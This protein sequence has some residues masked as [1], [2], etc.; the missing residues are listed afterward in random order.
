MNLET[1]NEL[2][3]AVEAKNFS[4]V[5]DIL[6][7]KNPADIAN[8]I[9]RFKE[10]DIC[11]I[12]SALTVEQSGEIILELPEDIRTNVLTKLDNKAILNFIEELDSD[13]AADLISFSRALANA[14]ILV[15]LIESA[16]SFK[17]PLISNFLDSCRL[18]PRGFFAYL[19]FI[20]WGR[21]GK[22]RRINW[23]LV[24]RSG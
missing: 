10:E 24:S 9:I 14:H 21:V 5:V 20:Y 16:I 6:K 15:D 3:V 11:D 8:V 12:L 4:S 22:H 19:I 18:S 23:H 1:F 17:K 2:K 7:K 13:D